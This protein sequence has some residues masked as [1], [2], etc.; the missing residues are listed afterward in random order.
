MDFLGFMLFSTIEGVS[1]YALALYLF[2]YNFKHYLM[3][4]LII[5]EIINLQNLLT[6]EELS[7]LAYIAPIVNIVITLLFFKTIARLP[8]I[9]SI[10]MTIVGFLGFAVLQTIIVLI[11]NFTIV[12]VNTNQFKGYLL[13]FLTG[14]I[15]TG[16]G[17]YLYKRGLGFTFD[18]EKWR[19]K[20]EQLFVTIIIIGFILALV[21][22]M[23]FQDIYANVFGFVV[24]LIIFLVYSIKK[25]ASSE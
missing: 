2:R 16:I 8:F 25:E 7:S 11:C 6:R 17:W 13:Q 10:F 1:M 18:F 5:I 23:Y 14:V 15:G 21:A 12:E 9:Q 20:G 22:M 3:H 19:F 24:A 4:S